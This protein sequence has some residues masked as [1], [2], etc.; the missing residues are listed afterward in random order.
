MI[1]YLLKLQRASNLLKEFADKQNKVNE[2]VA[3]TFESHQACFNQIQIGF[4]SHQSRLN[5]LENIIHNQPY[6]IQN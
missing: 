5:I 2:M 4:G 6:Y 3:K 1:R